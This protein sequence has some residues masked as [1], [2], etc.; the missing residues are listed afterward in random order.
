MKHNS[1]S[2]EISGKQRSK[3]ERDSAELLRVEM[4]ETIKV[5]K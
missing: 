1:G 5:L 4:E 2:S 3:P